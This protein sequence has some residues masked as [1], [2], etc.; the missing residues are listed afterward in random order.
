MKIMEEE[1]LKKER[2]YAECEQKERADRKLQ[3]P[4][5]L[6]TEVVE[7]TNSDFRSILRELF[8]NS[9]ELVTFLF[10]VV[11]PILANVLA[12]IAQKCCT[13]S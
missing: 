1:G 9:D 5:K 13:I 11:G 3:E 8:G 2:Q 12:K 10:N 7:H 6:K 4:E